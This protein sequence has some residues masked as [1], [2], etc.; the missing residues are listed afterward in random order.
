MPIQWIPDVQ[1]RR[2]PA[3]ERCV[4]PEVLDWYRL[5]PQ[6]RW[7]ESMR[8]WDTFRLL[9]GKLEPESDTQSPFDDA[10]TRRG[11]AAHGRTGLRAVRRSGV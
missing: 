4:D 6:E 8:L 11:G 10:R 9:G 3:L 1:P 2:S 5:S 7:T